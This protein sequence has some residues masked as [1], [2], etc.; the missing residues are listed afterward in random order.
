MNDRMKCLIAIGASVGSNCKHSIKYHVK[1]AKGSG[2]NEQE[3]LEAIEIA[4]MIN[5][6]II[7]DLA[8]HPNYN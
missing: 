3:I 1:K 5:L 7:K 6:V 8:Q 2:A 4:K